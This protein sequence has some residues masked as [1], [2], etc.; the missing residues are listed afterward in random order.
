[1]PILTYRQKEKIVNALDLAVGATLIIVG[2]FATFL[3]LWKVHFPDCVPHYAP[4]IFRLADDASC[5]Y[6]W[7]K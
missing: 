3:A 7:P 2:I 1:M 5:K 4:A 6:E